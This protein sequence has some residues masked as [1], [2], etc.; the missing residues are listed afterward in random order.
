MWLERSAWD[1]GTAV[2]VMFFSRQS[3]YPLKCC[4]TYL[5]RVKFLGQTC[6]A[7]RNLVRISHAQTQFLRVMCEGLALACSKLANFQR[8]A[9]INQ[10]NSTKEQSTSELNP[11]QVVRYSKYLFHVHTFFSSW[12][13]Q[14][15][16]VHVFVHT[17]AAVRV[18]SSA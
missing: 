6:C 18:L 8:A 14:L 17:S 11:D 5:P 3:A 12:A 7:C 10:V 2:V 4:A 1:L 13:L 15:N 9:F 16:I